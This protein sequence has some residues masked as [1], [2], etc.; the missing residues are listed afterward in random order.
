MGL[1]LL[2][3]P[4]P[5]PPPR[6]PLPS[7]PRL[8]GPELPSAAYPCA[9]PFA[10]V[11]ALG[12]SARIQCELASAALSGRLAPAAP[13]PRPPDP[14][15]PSLP[16]PRPLTG[17]FDG[18][19][20]P[21]PPLPPPLEVPLAKLSPRADTGGL[22]L[23]RLFC[24]LWD[25]VEASLE[26]SALSVAGRS[27]FFKGCFASP[28]VGQLTTTS[29]RG[30]LAVATGS[31][32]SRRLGFVC[33]AGFCGFAASDFAAA[34]PEVSSVWLDPVAATAG[35]ACTRPSAAGMS[36]TTC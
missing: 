9:W 23:L 15:A 21:S 35:S 13:T 34:S 26:A 32:A 16:V 36:G 18:P 20:P 14:A 22:V 30:A 4:L 7:L 5:L 17:R 2:S 8:P 24:G 11:P 27:F 12:A 33:Q 6:P 31:W 25:C 10:E 1:L 29:P 3:R 19:R 28:S